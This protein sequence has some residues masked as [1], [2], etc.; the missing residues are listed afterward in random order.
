MGDSYKAL[1]NGDLGKP[2]RSRKKAKKQ[3]K[4][5]IPESL[6]AHP[7]VAAEFVKRMTGDHCR[8]CDGKGKW[9]NPEKKMLKCPTCKG[10][11]KRPNYLHPLRV[12]LLSELVDAIGGYNASPPL[13]LGRYGSNEDALGNDDRKVVLDLLKS[14][15]HQVEYP[16]N[17]KMKVIALRLFDA[18]AE[19]RRFEENKIERKQW[20]EKATEDAGFDRNVSFDV[21]WAAALKALRNGGAGWTACSDKLPLEATGPGHT[22]GWTDWLECTNGDATDSGLVVFTAS[23]SHRLRRWHDLNQQVR[24][25][26]HYRLLPTKESIQ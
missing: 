5:E 15:R 1:M 12:A 7:Q 22:S 25:V 9:K 21:V 14:Y 3:P 4:I 18:E 17:E 24:G 26:T 10:T 19:L 11:G 13:S 23:Y 6:K 20:L 16:L 2:S 8:M